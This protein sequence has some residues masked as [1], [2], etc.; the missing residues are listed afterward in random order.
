MTRRLAA[1]LLL[2][3]VIAILLAFFLLTDEA[4]GPSDAGFLPPC[5]GAA[6]QAPSLA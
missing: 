2:A 5:P 6:C 1:V 4:E 3:I